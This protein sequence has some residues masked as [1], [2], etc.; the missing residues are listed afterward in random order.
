MHKS[1]LLCQHCKMKAEPRPRSSSRGFSESLPLLGLSLALSYI[2]IRGI[3]WPSRNA[4]ALLHYHRGF[5]FAYK[6][7]S[8]LLCFLS[9]NFWQK[10]HSSIAKRI[11]KI[12]VESSFPNT[13]AK[14]PLFFYCIWQS[15]G[16]QHKWQ[17]KCL[18]M[19]EAIGKSS[20]S[21]VG[22]WKYS[23]DDM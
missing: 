18:Q 2:T 1:F 12:W 16:K 19:R 20:F 9:L 14:I 4:E 6:T 15:F 5:H 22:W 7:Q 21:L 13:R 23:K 17:N 10:N 11:W 3:Y 8:Q